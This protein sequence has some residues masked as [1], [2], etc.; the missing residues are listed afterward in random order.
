MIIIS[1]HTARECDTYYKEY[2][3]GGS[4][5]K[6]WNENIQFRGRNGYVVASNGVMS[7]IDSKIGKIE[8]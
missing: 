3:K 2:S 7:K 5:K 1:E 8:I 6:F 4:V